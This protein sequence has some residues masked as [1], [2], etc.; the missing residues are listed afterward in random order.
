MVCSHC[1][2]KVKKSF[3]LCPN[4]GEKVEIIRK[5]PSQ[6]KNVK[7]IIIAGVAILILSLIF[8]V[9]LSNSKKDVNQLKNSVVQVFVYDENGN[10]IATGSGVVA[11]KNDVVLTNAHVVEDNY[12]LEVISENNT[13]YKVEGIIAYNKKKDIAILKLADSKGLKALSIKEKVKVGDEVT[14]IGSP[15]GLKN[16]VSDG[17]LSGYYQ[18]SIEVYQ[19]TA[20]ISSGSSGGA[21][22]DNKGNLVGITYASINGGQN[23]NLA[24]PIAEFKKEYKIVKDNK[25]I[26][27]RYYNYLN[28]S[29]FKTK[30]GN[31]ILDYA[32]SDE[33]GNDKFKSGVIDESKKQEGNLE[34]CNSLS[35]CI[36]VNDSNYNKVSDYI[37]ASFYLD[38]GISGSVGTVNLDGT[39]DY[40]TAKEGEGYSIVVIK[41]NDSSTNAI[42]QLQKFIKTEFEVDGWEFNN[43]SKYLYGLSCSN[44]N[45][46]NEVRSILEQFT[47]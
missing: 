44:Y 28:N 21:L 8:I 42:S 17:I 5:S 3:N 27:T 25:S 41:L 26:A 6:K 34:R 7:F 32:L 18:D 12:K 38:S 46:C 36:Y 2:S 1:G 35:N 23:L 33:Y 9:V 16:T 29:I 40:S 39:I 4:C 15:L 47:K 14:A 10:A 13:K 20:P 24:I 31:A 19:H 30:N 45:K 37:S 11:F 22:F 43:N